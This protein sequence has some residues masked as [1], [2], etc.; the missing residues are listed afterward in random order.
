MSIKIES[1]LCLIGIHVAIVLEMDIMQEVVLHPV[2][3]AKKM[4]IL[5]YIVRTRRILKMYIY[6][7]VSLL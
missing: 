3:F 6:K 5:I 1:P 4:D 7:V 2:K